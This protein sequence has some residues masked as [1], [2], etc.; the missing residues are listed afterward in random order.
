MPDTFL[1]L[2]I[3]IKQTVINKIYKTLHFCELVGIFKA[4]GSAFLLKES[5]P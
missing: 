3:G 1:G 4:I 5:F 2:Q